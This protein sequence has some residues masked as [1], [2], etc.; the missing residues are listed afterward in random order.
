MRSTYLRWARAGALV[1]LVG[2]LVALNTG[3]SSCNPCN[4]PNPC[5]KPCN[6]PNPC[7]KPC[8]APNPC[9]KPCNA[10]NPCAKPC[11]APNPCA[12]PC[13]APNP[14][15]KP[16]NAP[17][18]CAPP[19]CAPPPCAPPKAPCAPPPPVACAPQTGNCGPFPANAK[20]GE[21]WCCVWI[22]PVYK[23]E[24][25]R[26]CTCPEK[27]EQEWVPPVSETRTRQVVKCPASRREIP[28]AAEYKTVEDCI[29]TCPARTEWQRVECTPEQLK[30][31]E[32]QGE[33]WALVTIPAQF[34]KRSRQVCTREA[35]V[36]YEEIPAVMETETYQVEVQC[37]FNKTKTIPA[38]YENRPK[39]TCTADGRWEW[40]RNMACVVPTLPANN[41]CTP[42]PQPK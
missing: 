10:P 3:C 25:E 37:G 14:C 21:A 11:N 1:A 20:P 6:A 23:Q 5:A 28:I 16:C 40:R 7:A 26:I 42:Q 24:M 13:N 38:V 22:P 17:N 39:Q 18:P 29:E 35:S 41:P 4:A 2:G 30:E 32:K 8:N 31:G 27:C 12:K 36:R 19:P 34:E 9:A 15:A 33:C